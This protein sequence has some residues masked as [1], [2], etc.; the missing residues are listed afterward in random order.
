VFQLE[1][2]LADTTVRQRVVIW[3]AIKRIDLEADLSGF[4]GKLWREFRLALPLAMTKPQLAYEVPFGVVEIGKDEIPGTGG[5]AYGSLTY[6]D[7]CK[8]IHPRVMQD[9]VDASDATGGVTMSSSVSVF[10][11]EGA[12]LQPILLASRRSCNGQGNWYPQAGDH[13]NRFSITSGAGGWRQR[14]REGIAA[15]NPFIPVAAKPGGELPP[16]KSFASL[17]ASNVLISTIKKCEDDDSVV[18]RCYEIEGRDN[19]VT[20][21]L[22]QPIQTAEKTNLIE[23][24]GKP[25]PVKD[26][27]VELP[28]G[29]Q[30]IETMKLSI[31]S[32]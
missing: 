16:L 20:L 3:N 6:S 29:H 14:W 21:R 17:S 19:P 25:L 9:F 18:V 10:D 24:D 31:R 4:T 5:H 8:D 7:Q 28:V 2:P 26:G 13:R 30:A 1:Q 12:C 15:N 22:F 27:A 32:K 23:E 11:W